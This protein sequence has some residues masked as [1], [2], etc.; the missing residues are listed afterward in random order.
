MLPGLNSL[1][2]ALSRV[3]DGDELVLSGGSYTGTGTSVATIAQNITI[4]AQNPGG[5]VL[6]GEN[7]RRVLQISAGT[8]NLVGLRITNGSS[9]RVSSSAQL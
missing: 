4:R 6:D 3:S 1:Q 2:A 7:A 9:I 8:I 5:A